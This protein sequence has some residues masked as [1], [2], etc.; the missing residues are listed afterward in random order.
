MRNGTVAKVLPSIYDDNI[1][2]KSC[3]FSYRKLPLDTESMEF[4]QDF[5]LY[6]WE[7]DPTLSNDENLLD[8]CVIVTRSSKLRNGSMACILVQPERNDGEETLNICEKIISIATNR[9]LFGDDTSDVHAEVAAISEISK[10]GLGP[11]EHATAYITM[12]PCKRCFGALVAAGIRKIVTRLDPPKLIQDGAARNKIELVTFRDHGQQT[13]R[14]N[15]LIY[16]D[17]SGK[18]RRITDED[19]NRVEKR[20][21]EDSKDII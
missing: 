14:I 5:E 19:S 17:P 16:G 12:P 3:A 20:I 18:R 15:T 4:L 6:G 13:S 11:T 21:K 2:N 10:R 7:P 1:I 9:P 8:L